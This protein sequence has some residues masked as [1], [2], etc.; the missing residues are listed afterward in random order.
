MPREEKVKFGMAVVVVGGG[1][2]GEGESRQ[3]W[4]KVVEM[5]K[6]EMTAWT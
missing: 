5:V 6:I 3:G 2:N 4:A 1:D